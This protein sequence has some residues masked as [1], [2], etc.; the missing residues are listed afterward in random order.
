[1]VAETSAEEWI[2]SFAA[3]VGGDP[4]DEELIGKLLK[5]A[6]VAA[7]SS[8]RIAAPIACWIAGSAGIEVDRAIEAAEGLSGD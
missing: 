1:V 2:Q 4:P 3:A 8:E 7:H 5:L 6:A